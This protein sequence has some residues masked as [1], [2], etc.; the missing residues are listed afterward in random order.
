[1]SAHEQDPDERGHPILA[2][3]RERGIPLPEDPDL[4]AA[5]A[6][7]E[8]EGRLPDELAEA[9]AALLD[10]AWQIDGGRGTSLSGETSRG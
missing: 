6:T 1:M 3:A 7:L 9:L 8:P 10:F 2:R 5:L 4:A